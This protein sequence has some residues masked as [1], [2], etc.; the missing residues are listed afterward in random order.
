[1][2]RVENIRGAP[3]WRCPRGHLV[4]NTIH[5]YGAMTLLYGSSLAQDVAAVLQ[6]GRE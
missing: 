4:S 2:G 3:L 5:L 6:C 1:M